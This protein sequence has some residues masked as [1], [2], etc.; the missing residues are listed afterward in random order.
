MFFYRNPKRSVA[1]WGSGLLAAGWMVM[2][3]Q[4]Q[5]APHHIGGV[6]Q[7]GGTIRGVIK[8][9]GRKAKRKPI[10][11]SADAFCQQA[12]PDTPARNE[13]Y[14]FGDNDT[15]V[16]VF[17][18]V[19]KGLEGKSIPEPS[20]QASIDQQGCMYVPHVSGVMVNQPLQ[21]LNSDNTLHNVKMNSAKNGS[22][23]EGMPVKGMVLNKRFGKPE[24]GIAL[25]C[26]VHPWMSAYLHVVAHPYFAVSG[27]DGT[28]EIRGLPAGQYEL[29]VWHEFKK[30]AP[31]KTEVSVT[32]TDGQAEQ[33]E[34]TYGPKKKK[35]R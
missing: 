5:A 8:F 27:Q 33:V 19:S 7:P 15:L 29:S 16:N 32:V 11:M 31:D 9:E 25:K 10:R 14:V 4:V 35:K 6:D 12:H 34:F 26:D 20:G 17:V 21:I 1:T 24:A 18:W 30:F 23:N 3:S 28:F 22:F 13:R 2:F